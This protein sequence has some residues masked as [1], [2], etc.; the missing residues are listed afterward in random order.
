MLPNFDLVKIL[1]FFDY[2][3]RITQ[4]HKRW[5]LKNKQELSEAFPLSLSQSFDMNAIFGVLP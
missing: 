5:S 3:V 4:F 1:Q 2:H